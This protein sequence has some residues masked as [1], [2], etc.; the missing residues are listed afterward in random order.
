MRRSTSTRNLT[1]N[2]SAI[3]WVSVMIA[4]DSGA[5]PDPEQITSERG[6]GQCADPG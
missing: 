1:P 5:S 6:V 4:F 3:V 2:V